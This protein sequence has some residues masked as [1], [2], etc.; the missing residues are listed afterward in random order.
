MLRNQKGMQN[1]WKI[2]FRGK[3]FLL[4]ACLR[5]NYSQMSR[6]KQKYH[7]FNK[8][9]GQTGAGLQLVDIEDGTDTCNLVGRWLVSNYN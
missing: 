9:L 5:G 8:S 1:L 6:L 4:C 7:E 3:L 2:I